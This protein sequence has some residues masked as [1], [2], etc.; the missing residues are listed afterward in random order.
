MTLESSFGH[1]FQVNGYLHMNGASST[2]DGFVDLPLEEKLAVL[3]AIMIN[4][5]LNEL[6]ELMKY[7][8]EVSQKY[9][10]SISRA[11]V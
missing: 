8:T 2:P 7:H 3:H 10:S 9:G 11:P 4:S 6:H 5:T 1:S